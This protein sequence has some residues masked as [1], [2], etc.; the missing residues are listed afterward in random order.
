MIHH[1][2]NLLRH[3]FIS[4][5]DEITED[6]Q[7][8]FQPPDEKW[9]THVTGQSGNVLNVYLADVRENRKL[10]SN[11][12]TRV[13]ENGMISEKPAPARIDCHYLITAWSPSGDTAQVEA[14][15]DEHGLLYK[16]IAVLM[17][18]EVLV[19]R[20]VYA[21]G[22]LPN[23]FPEAIVDDEIPLAV[24]P[25]E[26]FGKLPEFWGTVDWRWKPMIYLVVTLPVLTESAYAAGPQVTAVRLKQQLRGKP[27]T[28]E[29]SI[30]IAGIVSD[31]NDPAVR[32]EG[33]QALLVGTP[34]RVFTNALG[35]YSFSILAA[36]DYVLEVSKDGFVTHTRNIKVP[37][38]NEQDETY[39]VELTKLP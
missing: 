5:I 30:R 1:L 12:R 28:L 11:A 9:R 18:R 6:G 16:A 35:Q 4:G 33:A 22:E 31:A 29:E 25:V 21:P 32:L 8:G 24:L 37:R 3:L 13:M 23:G 2:D 38:E 20:Q 19:P 10:R 26:G 39:N 15:L 34:H 7:V 27:G 17:N 36:G 14:T